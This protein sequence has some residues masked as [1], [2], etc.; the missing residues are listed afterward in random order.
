MMNVQSQLYSLSDLADESPVWQFNVPIY[1]RLYVWGDDQVQ[2]LLNDLINAFERKAPLFFLGGTLLVEQPGDKTG[3]RFDLIDGQQR[4]TTLWLLCSAWGKALEPFLTV[5]SDQA[6]VTPRLHFAIRPAVNQLL[7]SLAE[8]AAPNCLPDE[9]GTE[10]LGSAISQMHSVFAQRGEA[11]DWEGLTRFVF[12]QVKFV[13]TTVPRATDL[14]KLFEVINNRGVQL[15]HHEILK[16][17]ML[18]KLGDAER[19]SYAVLWDVCSD[20]E[21]YVERTLS[22]LSRLQA[23]FVCEKLY[24]NGLMAD[25]GAVKSLMNSE[26]AL[27]GSGGA[28]TLA[29]ILNSTAE[30][31]V[32]ETKT[33]Q[34][35]TGGVTRVRSIIS[36]PLLLQHA[37]RIWL[38]ERDLPDMP[39]ILDRELLALFDTHF[40]KV[41]APEETLADKIRSFIDLLWCVRVLF[42]EHVIKWVDQGRDEVHLISN[43]SISISTSKGHRY[44]NRTTESD[45]H[46]GLALLQSMLYHSQEITTH[47]WLTPFLL[48]VRQ[49]A[50]DKA[51]KHFRYLQHLDNH[52]LCSAPT[53]NLAARTRSFMHEPWQVRAMVYQDCLRRGDGVRLAHYWFYKLEFVLWFQKRR[54]NDGWRRFRLTAKNSVEHISPQSPSQHDGNRVSNTTLNHFGNLALVSRSINSEY[55][56]L[57]FNE[58]RQRFL[59]K[60]KQ[61]LDS[62]KMA[63]IYEQEAWGDDH[64]RIHQAE[65]LEYLD[66]YIQACERQC[67]TTHS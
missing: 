62:L 33:Q 46:A 15:Q 58:K 20:M 44:I 67:P 6:A 5:L 32:E 10:R 23:Y 31:Q 14:N 41:L 47:Y 18:E 55:S 8:D 34:D 66:E 60:N 2:T 7:Q 16:A 51:E 49:H 59:N 17:R 38:F 39:R 27:L 36:F 21:Q 28:R 61:G 42:D 3:R 30:R 57:P 45:A 40:F 12:E 24:V 22:A 48:H 64:A 65:M 53:E 13:V 52:L 63:L 37:L 35:E 1:Q 43:I 50:G 29:D 56:N 26:A 4:F 54:N 9:A 25:A 11:G 19:S